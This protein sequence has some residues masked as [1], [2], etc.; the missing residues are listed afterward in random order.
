M[1]NMKLIQGLSADDLKRI[2]LEIYP[3]S[4]PFSLQV[5]S[6]RCKTR[7]GV[8]NLEKYRIRIYNFSNA[9]DAK[10]VAIHEYAHHLNNTEWWQSGV[11][12]Y[13]YEAKHGYKFWY[14]YTILIELANK[15]GFDISP[16]YFGRAGR[17]FCIWKYNNLDYF[18]PFV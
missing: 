14:I 7:L 1:K 3:C 11:K 5:S 10:E 9:Y 8:Y 2:H 16:R 6:R 18:D 12:G 15:N 13:K 4:I 17:M